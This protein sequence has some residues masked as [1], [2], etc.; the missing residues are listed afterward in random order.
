MNKILKKIKFLHFIEGL[1]NYA[2]FQGRVNRREYWF[3]MLYWAI[4]YFLLVVIQ[5]HLA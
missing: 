1:K 2:V 4:C 5:F 3:F